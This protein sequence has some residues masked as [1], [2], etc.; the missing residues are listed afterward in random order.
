MSEKRRSLSR[1][2]AIAGAAAAGVGAGAYVL[3]RGG[4]EN[5]DSASAPDCVLAPEQTE[6]PHYI[7]N[8]VSR[9]NIKGGRTGVP[10]S[11]RLQVL[12]PTTCKPIKGSPVEV[13]HC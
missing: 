7:D 4:P 5:A 10:L 11:L 12:N 13:W 6:A 8:H 3:L 2:E 1:R 9:S